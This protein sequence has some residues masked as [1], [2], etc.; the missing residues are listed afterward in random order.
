MQGPLGFSSSLWKRVC[1]NGLWECPR[2]LS[3]SGL[4]TGWHT[5]TD[6]GNKQRL[7]AI[8]A[9]KVKDQLFYSMKR[10]ANQSKCKAMQSIN[11]LSE[12]GPH[13][14]CRPGQI[15]KQ[16]KAKGRGEG[17]C[18]ATFLGGSQLCIALLCF[19]LFVFASLCFACL[20]LL[21]FA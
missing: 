11:P 21:R 8:T 18:S 3:G 2:C 10:K 6:L 20:A 16:S 15:V 5:P 7:V 12:P 9:G 14:L 4:A 17:R 19:A 13:R 1:A